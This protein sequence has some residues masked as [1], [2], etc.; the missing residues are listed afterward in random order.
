M[1][2]RIDESRHPCRT[3]T[4]DLNQSPLLP[5]KWTAL[6]ALSYRF[7]KRHLTLELMLYFLIVAHKVSCHTSL[8]LGAFKPFPHEE[9]LQFEPEYNSGFNY[10]AHAECQ[11]TVLCYSVVAVK[12]GSAQ[13]TRI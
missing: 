4:V 12:K 2:K 1:L 6:W 10:F 5:L 13:N 9:V 7:S 8:Y 3:P 11:R